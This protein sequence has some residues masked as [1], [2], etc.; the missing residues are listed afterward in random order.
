MDHHHYHHAHKSTVCKSMNHRSNEK[1]SGMQK[2]ISKLMKNVTS[3]LGTRISRREPVVCPPT[4]ALLVL[5]NKQK[6][7]AF[8]RRCRK[9]PE[10]A[11]FTEL[12]PGYTVLHRVIRVPNVP[13]E[14]V[15]ALLR[16]HPDSVYQRNDFGRTILFLNNYERLEPRIFKLLLDRCTPPRAKVICSA[17]G[18]QIPEDV[19]RAHIRPFLPIVPLMHDCIGHTVLQSMI[20]HHV[21][22]YMIQ[23]LLDACPELIYKKTKSQRTPLHMACYCG[24]SIEM[25]EILIEAYPDAVNECDRS[26]RTPFEALLLHNAFEYDHNKLFSIFN[27]DTLGGLFL[28]G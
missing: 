4:K 11:E 18:H 10:D 23:M 1:R 17:L 21:P 3:R 2:R 7:D 15:D 26:D 19:V 25:L 22:T 5:A 6:W 9:H 28:V 24:V 27:V 14:A 20:I 12:G 13:Y 16:A 8:I